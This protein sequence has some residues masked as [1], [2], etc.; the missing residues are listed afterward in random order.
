MR[1]SQIAAWIFATLLVGLHCLVVVRSFSPMR[2]PNGY[3]SMVAFFLGVPL[4]I[5]TAGSA[6][7]GLKR[8]KD[9]SMWV[10]LIVGLLPIVGWPSLFVLEA[11]RIVP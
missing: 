4:A 6:I 1:N 9:R 8:S 3:D 10:P 11:L 7:V 2:D 5:A